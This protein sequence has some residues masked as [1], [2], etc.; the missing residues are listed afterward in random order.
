MQFN[1][2]LAQSWLERLL[3][4]QEATRSSRVPPMFSYRLY[5]RHENPDEGN[6]QWKTYSISS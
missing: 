5:H 6:N 4:M 2:R 3:D 1:G